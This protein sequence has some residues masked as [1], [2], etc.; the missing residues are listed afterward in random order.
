VVRYRSL[1]TNQVTLLVGPSGCGKTTVLG[2]INRMH[3]RSGRKVSGSIR[4]G[5]QSGQLR[6]P[7][8][9]WRP[10]LGTLRP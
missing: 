9:G 8:G 3:D 1:A 10:F 7:P 5:H 2:A 4:L 6:K